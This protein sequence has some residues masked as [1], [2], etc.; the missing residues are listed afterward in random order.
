MHSLF[1]R[2]NALFAFSLTVTGVLAIGL[3][4]TTFLY[5][6]NGTVKIDASRL[7]VYADKLIFFLLQILISINSFYFCFFKKT[8]DRI[9]G[10]K[11]EE[12]FRFFKL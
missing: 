3:Y 1:S 9:W 8:H 6:Q 11:K 5:E 2:L 10:R 12:R 7:V 4:A